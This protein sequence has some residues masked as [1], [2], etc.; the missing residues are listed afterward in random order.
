MVLALA[1]DAYT[2]LSFGSGCDPVPEPDLVREDRLH[3]VGIVVIA[4]LPWLVAGIRRKGGTAVLVAGALAA[5]PSFIWAVYGIATDSAWVG[6][7]CIQF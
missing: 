5:V 6:G 2:L 3:L 1:A 4:V 7:L